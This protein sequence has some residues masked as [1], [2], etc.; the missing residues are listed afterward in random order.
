MMMFEKWSLGWRI[1]LDSF[2]GFLLLRMIWRRKVEHLG[3]MISRH[4]PLI[5]ED[6]STSHFPSSCFLG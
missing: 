2:H 5:S 4:L 6:V 1:T 3:V